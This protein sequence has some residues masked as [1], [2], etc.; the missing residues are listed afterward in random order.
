MVGAAAAGAAASRTVVATDEDITI[1]VLQL[2]IDILLQ[3]RQDR[4]G[5][6]PPLSPHQLRPRQSP[7]ALMQCTGQPGA[8]SSGSEAESQSSGELLCC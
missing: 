7:D 1:L 6:H 3:G 4:E 8:S 2:P 5:E